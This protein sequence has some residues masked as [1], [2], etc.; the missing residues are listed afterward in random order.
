MTGCYPGRTK[1]LG[2]HGPR[3]RGLDPSFATM[4][5]IFQRAG[6]RTGW[7]GKWHIGDQPE[8]RPQARGFEETAGLMVSNDM[9]EHHPTEPEV[10][11]KYPLQYWSN[12]EVIC[13]RV[14]PEFQKTLTS[15]VAKRSVDFIQRHKDE[16]FFL[17]AAPSMPHVPLFC[18]EAFE[19]RS[20]AG[21][22]GDVILELDDMVGQIMGALKDNG[23]EDNTIVFFSS[24]NGPWSG[25]GNHA[26]KTPFRE[27]K[28]TGF[29]GGTH[30]ACILR[31]PGEIPAGTSSDAMFCSVDLLPTLCRLTGVPLPESA[32]D[33]M[34]VWPLISGEPGAVNPHDYYPVST[35]KNLD[36]VMSGDG[37]WKL[38]LP[39]GYRHVVEYGNDGMPGKY[40]KRTIGLSLFDLKND[41]T[42]STNVIAAHPEIADRLKKLA[43]QHKRGFYE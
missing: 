14:T 10:W 28:G 21:L 39:H 31:Y 3:E 13:E 7:F 40:E 42:E 32:I 26:G 29:D 38:H 34:D 25:F 1:M 30:V 36:G 19:G 33:G 23:L 41:P 16:P 5:E 43:E 4:G 11:G 8:T 12:G 27:A 24:D 2:A 35:L 9:W 18:S 20:G 15:R 22:Y 37:R 6:Y 17:Y